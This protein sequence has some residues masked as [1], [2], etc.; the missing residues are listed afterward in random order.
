VEGWPYIVITAVRGVPLCQVWAGL[1]ATERLA[2]VRQCGAFIAWLH[3]VPLAGLDAIAIDW[4]AFAA[5]QSQN[6]V[7]QVEN[8]GLSPSWIASIR[9]ALDRIVCESE[10]DNRRV[11][12]SADVTDEHIMVERRGGSWHLAGY[13][14]F[15]DAMLGHPLYDFSAPGCSIVRGA[16]ELARA[17]L[18]GYGYAAGDLN[19]NLSERLTAYMLLHRYVTVT[20]LLA[21]FPESSRSLAEL[22]HCLWP[23]T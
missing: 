21:L 18:L 17:L 19:Q 11:L 16:P 6:R 13:I 10:A 3:T 12:L 23:L 15:G 22:Q 4:P 2:I 20:D 8:A 7:K 9:E 1:S 5:R 14:D